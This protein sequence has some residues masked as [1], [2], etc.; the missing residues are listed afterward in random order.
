[1]II[2]F[3]GTRGVCAVYEFLIL[4][5]RRDDALSV[6]G[7]RCIIDQV[8][9]GQPVRPVVL[10]ERTRELVVVYGVCRL[11]FGLAPGVE[12]AVTTRSRL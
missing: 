3:P 1:M 9:D 4:L 8:E 6:K 2:V 7:I 10:G 11:G 12:L 5:P